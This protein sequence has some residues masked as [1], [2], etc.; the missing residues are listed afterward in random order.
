MSHLR[1][2]C[3][4]FLLPSV[5]LLQSASRPS[6]SPVSRPAFVPRVIRHVP[7]PSSVSAPLSPPSCALLSP[8]A[9]L[10]PTAT[11]VLLLGFIIFIHESGHFLAAKLQNIRVKTFSI[12]FGP[13][14]FA[15]TPKNSETE[16]TL[17]LLPLGGYVAFPEH[18]TVDPDTGEVKESDDPDLLQNRPVKDRALVISA[19]VI[20]NIILAWTSLL[21][22][23][24]LV[25]VPTYSFSPGVTIAN[26]VD[27]GGAASA[28]GVRKG[29][30]IQSVDGTKIKGYAESAG[31]VADKIRTSRGR[32]MLFGIEREGRLMSIRVAP[33]CCSADGSAAMGVQLVPNATVTRQRP[34]TVGKIIGKTNDEFTR[35]SLQT[36]KGLTSILGN[37][38]KSSQSLSG[39][40]GVV[41][42]GA[43]LARND[44]V[45]LL[46][47]CAVISINLAL[48]NSLP[49]PA[50]DGGQMAFLLIEW[51]RGTPI[52][53]KLQDTINRTAVLLFLA[54]S[55]VLFFGD[56]EKLNLVGAITKLFG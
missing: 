5:P 21:F 23:V 20:A 4:A 32:A 48:I 44:A 34:E 29:D 45:A 51:I 1:S 13:S 16:F 36:W 50:L 24:G 14:L 31:D 2:S 40:I 52:S 39:P 27:E 22:S 3:T 37:F 8:I 38:A 49:V 46:T 25:G 18:A 26:I 19:G 6:L 53:S 28:A 54:F 55:G 7:P 33:K 11:G 43:D 56:L 10:L 15:F 47:F 12:G 42:M 30:I 17:R 41:S 9:S 35:L